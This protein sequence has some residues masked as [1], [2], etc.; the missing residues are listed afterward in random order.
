MTL[1]ELTKRVDEL[2][3]QLAEVQKKMANSSA[4]QPWWMT[5]AGRFKNDPVFDEIVRLGREYRE[6]LHPDRKK[7]KKKKA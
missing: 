6:S 2:E 1:S 7:K 5:G 4:A 3:K